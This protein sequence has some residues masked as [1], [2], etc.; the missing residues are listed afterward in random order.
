MPAKAGIQN[1]LKILD[2]RLRGND[3]KGGFKTVYETI[4]L[5]LSASGGF[6]FSL[7]RLRVHIRYMALSAIAP[8]RMLDPNGRHRTRPHMTGDTIASHLK[9]MGNGRRCPGQF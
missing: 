9:F 6:G 8:R 1:Y 4:N 3:A 2:S 7:K 5:Q